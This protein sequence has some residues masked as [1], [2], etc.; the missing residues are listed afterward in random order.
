VTHEWSANK[1]RWCSTFSELHAIEQSR[2]LW[3]SI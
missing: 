1:G 3:V 2:Q